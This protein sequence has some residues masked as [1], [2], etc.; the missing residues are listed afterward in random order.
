MNTETK[1]P[2][3]AWLPLVVGTLLVILFAGLGAWQISRGLEKQ[4]D[5][6]AFSDEGSFMAWRDGVDVRPYQRLR[7]TGRYDVERQF[8]L[9]NIILNSRNGY[10]VIT[11]LLGEKEEPLLLVNRGWIEKGSEPLDR[12]LLNV[13]TTRV[14]VRG[15]AGSLPRA[16]YKMGDAMDPAGGWPRLAVY[17][18]SDEVA[19]ALDAPVQNFVLL[20]NHEEQHGFLRQW[21]PTAFGP[22]KH[23]G[24][25][26][27]WFVMAV[28]LA[29]L[30]T[31][32]YRKKRFQS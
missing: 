9:E 27:Q 5:R 18:S 20:M 12:R 1:K 24:Y 26:L 11:P 10:Y 15:R 14:T 28:V 16:G 19:A 30:L 13:P 32:N 21:T 22:G 25:A 31:W 2:L 7:A 23:F 3:P 6:A 8:L 4:A 29:A 17:P